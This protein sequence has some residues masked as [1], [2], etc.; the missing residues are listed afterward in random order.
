MAEATG[1]GGVTNNLPLLCASL[2]VLLGAQ[3]AC[4]QPAT[5]TKARPGPEAVK[6]RADDP[7]L[8]A[9]SDQARASI[10]V[11]WKAWDQPGPTDDA[12]RLNVGFPARGGG[13]ENSWVALSSRDGER[14][15]GKLS[16]QPIYFPGKIGDEV[17]F[18]LSAVSDWMFRRDGK[19]YGMFT[20]R[21]LL[22]RLSPAEAARVKAML[23]EA[24]LPSADH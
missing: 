13:I 10:E 11:F 12:F 16:N 18:D 7:S 3:T 17:N 22:P 21:A 5:S 2:I 23:S 9:A 24:P 20:T 4:D 6:S 1:A 19:I 15:V 14:A 8:E